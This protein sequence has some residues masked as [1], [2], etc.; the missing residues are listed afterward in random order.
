[1]LDDNSATRALST[2][3]VSPR[4][5]KNMDRV[6]TMSGSAVRA[7]QVRSELGAKSRDE[8]LNAALRMMSLHGYEGASVSKIA[9]ES[10]LPASSIYWHF[11]SKAG[12][13]AAVLER[14]ATAFFLSSREGAGASD[15]AVVDPLATL[16]E[17]FRQAQIAA[18]E[19]PEFLRLLFLLTLSGVHDER[20]TTVINKATAEGREQLHGL[21][22]HAFSGEGEAMSLRI[23]DEL[24][25][26][27]RATFDGAFLNSQ[28][29]PN[30][31]FAVLTDRMAETIYALATGII[32]RDG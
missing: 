15:R 22:R 21:I 10:G 14:G 16:R 23:A 24:A 8:I 12:V 25:D 9:A 26:Y 13:L 19:H 18:D 30:I 20:V 27:A 31:S 3:R 4:P 32:R 1:M 6:E 17:A 7:P 2:A 5:T 28:T 29:R 11:G